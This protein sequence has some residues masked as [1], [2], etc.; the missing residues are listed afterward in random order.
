MRP[1]TVG[2]RRPPVLSVGSVENCQV[3]DGS[4]SVLV[5]PA[6]TWIHGLRSGGPAS[7]TQ[8]RAALSSES[9]FARM[10]PA[11]PAPTIT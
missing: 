1:C 8:T 5:K 11:A 4:Q 7:S 10:E 2:M 6:G 3:T 9:R